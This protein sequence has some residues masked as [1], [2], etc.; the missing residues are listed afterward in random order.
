MIADRPGR[1]RRRGFGFV[2]MAMSGL[3][4]MAMVLITMQVVG[5]VAADRRAFARRDRAT[6]LVGQ[7]LEQS[8]ARP[9]ADLST[10]GLAALA[11]EANQAEPTAGGS[12]RVEV[13]P[14]PEVGGLAQKK[15]LVEFTWP[16][17]SKV[18]EAPVRLVAWTLA[19]KEGQP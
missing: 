17:R 3:L 12:L 19:R 9:W 1:S 14:A 8:L 4:L 15:I 11:R 18:A 16:D 6:R 2:E 13:A 10:E 7:V 5:W